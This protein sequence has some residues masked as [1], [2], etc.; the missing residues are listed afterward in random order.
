MTDYALLALEEQMDFN[1]TF[2]N[3]MMGILESEHE[4]ILNCLEANT[5]LE[6]EGNATNADKKKEK[7]SLWQRIKKFFAD[8][9]DKFKSKFTNN[10]KYAKKN[11]DKKK[12]KLANMN[13][14]GVTIKLLRYQ[15]F[16]AMQNCVTT[17]RNNLKNLS[18]HI[19]SGKSVEEVTTEKDNIMKPYKN[20]KGDLTEGLKTY[21]RV[22]KAT[23]VLKATEYSGDDAKKELENYINYCS[24]YETKVLPWL[25]K[26][27]KNIEDEI[28]AVE[29][30]LKGTSN[31][32][33]ASTTSNATEGFYLNLE[34]SYNTE[35]FDVIFEADNPDANDPNAKFDP[36]KV[37]VRVDGN[38]RNEQD[39]RNSESNADKVKGLSNDALKATK[40]LLEAEQLVCTSAMTILEE[41]FMVYVNVLDKVLKED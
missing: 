33:G 30:A 34:S 7:I 9:F 21:F 17:I 12:N 11:F 38:A 32:N 29:D 2:H 36:N 15:S 10:P 8:L 22:G 39:K 41:K 19:T 1:R 26:E 28:K 3:I 35:L 37:E 13:M 5:V 16:N 24:I 14:N 31:A 40:I 27:M 23:S 6:A 18:K 20:Q 25:Q 4:Y